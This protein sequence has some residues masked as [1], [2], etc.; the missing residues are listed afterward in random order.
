MDNKRATSDDRQAAIRTGVW[1]TRAVTDEAARDN[2]GTPSIRSAGASFSRRVGIRKSM[3]CNI[4]VK[5]G[6]AYVI[7]RKI[8]DISLVGAFVEMDTTGLAVGDPVEVVIG[9]SYNQRQIEHQISAEIVRIDTE[10]VG[11]RFSTY[12]NRTYTD[13]VNFLYAM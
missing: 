5:L 10:G 11:I 13:L 3:P 9:V 2:H 8:H 6:S 12:G 1:L 4:I 7:A